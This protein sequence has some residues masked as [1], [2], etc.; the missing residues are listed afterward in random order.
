MGKENVHILTT[1]KCYP[2]RTNRFKEIKLCQY[3][4]SKSSLIPA[5]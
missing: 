4:E 3:R 2:E 5:S 1:D